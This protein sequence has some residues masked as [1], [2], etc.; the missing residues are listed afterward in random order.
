MKGTSEMRYTKKKW[1]EGGKMVDKDNKTAHTRI[2]ENGL[3][4]NTG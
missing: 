3:G 2:K 1:G 4:S